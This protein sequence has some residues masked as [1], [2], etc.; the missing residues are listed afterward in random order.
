MIDFSSGY[1]YAEILQAML[2]RVDNSLDKRQGSLIQTALGPGAWYLE[3]LAILLGQI[4]GQ[5]SVLTATGDGLD[6]LVANRGLTRIAATPA[7]RK[8]IFD[9]EV[10]TGSQFR[11]INGDNS[12][13]F[14]S[15]EFLERSGANYV[16]EMTCQTAG[17]IGNS[18]SGNILP[19]SSGLSYLTYAVISDIITEGAD[20]ETDEALRTRYVAT[21]SAAPYG[22]NIAEYRQAILGIAG[23]GGVQIYPANVYKGG[24]TVLCSI[25]GD[26]YKPAS[27]ALVATVQDAICPPDDGAHTPSQNGYGIAPVG[28]AVDI[29]S[30]TALTVNVSCTVTFLDGIVNGAVTYKDAIKTAVEEY[31]KT[32]A[33]TWGNAVQGHKISYPVIVYAARVIYAIL[34]VPEVINVSNLRLNGQTG[35]LTLTENSTLQ[36][37]PVL[38]EVTVNA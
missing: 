26:D 13:I 29:V 6:Y 27:A 18:Y 12:V 32:V 9:G 21:L 10:P 33:Q 30:A 22:G 35:D 8:G 1:T 20:N 28:A 37:V 15:G 24:G 25:I 4:Q 5:G 36:Q 17:E 38:G 7:V 3:G 14:V 2:D 16:Y 19:V 34:T 23:V 11:T 31:I